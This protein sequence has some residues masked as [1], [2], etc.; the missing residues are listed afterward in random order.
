MSSNAASPAGRTANV[1]SRVGSLENIHHKPS[2]GEKKIFS[3]KVK[4]SNVT[5]KIGSLEN[6]HHAPGGGDK[7]V[8]TNKLDFAG[9]AKAKVGSLDN[10]ATP[11][12]KG[13]LEADAKANPRLAHAISAYKKKEKA[14]P[15][16]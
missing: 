16:A 5:S 11:Q 10:I 8:T 1:S 15:P 2:G 14:A 9:R 6:L 7:K 3:E 4:Y 13:T 12:K